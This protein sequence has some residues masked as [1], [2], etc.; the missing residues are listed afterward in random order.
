LPPSVP[1]LRLTQALRRLLAAR[2]VRVEVGMEVT[3]VKVENGA[4]QWVETSTSSRPLVHRAAQFVLATGGVLGGGFNSDHSG[5]FW[6]TVFD[7]PLTVPQ[8]RTQ[9]FRPQFF[10]EEGQPVFR[11]G[12][13]VN[14]SLQPVDAQGRLMLSN[15][16]V[17]GGALAGADSILE[18]SLEGVAIATGVAVAEAIL[19]ETAKV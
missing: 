17:A 16:H 2:G 4:V 8:D 5:R 14:R 1:G 3:G 7:L 9:W 6:E 19:A 12:V 15:V 11:G 18:R 10:D 13:A